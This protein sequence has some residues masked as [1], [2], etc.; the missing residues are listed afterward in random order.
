MNRTYSVQFR[1][2]REGKTDYRKRLRILLSQKPRLVVRKS[3]KNI[4]A[5]IVSYDIKGDKVIVAANS[6]ELEKLGWNVHKANLPA[7]YL[8]GLLIGIKAKKHKIKE[9]VLDIGLHTSGKGVKAYACLKGVIDAGLE[10]PH[11]DQILPSMER[12]RGEHIAKYASMLKEEERRYKNQFSKYISKGI[13]PENL[14]SLFDDV[15]NKI[16]EL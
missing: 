13:S 8:T 15:K 2:K 1:R 4:N 3:L 5:Q 16:L 12:I 9:L 14:P 6:R 10:I 7:A 11:S